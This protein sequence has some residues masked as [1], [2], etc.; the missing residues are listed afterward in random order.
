MSEFGTL[1]QSIESKRPLVVSTALGRRALRFSGSQYFEDLLV[2]PTD[3]NLHWFWAVKAEQVWSYH[4][5]MDSFGGGMCLWVTDS[6][7]YELNNCA[8]AGDTIYSAENVGDWQIV[9][10][11]V[12]G[13]GT[14]ILEIQSSST[15]TY[16]L[17]KMYADT[18]S[19]SLSYDIFHRNGGEAFRGDLGE[20]IVIGEALTSD[21]QAQ[22]MR[23]LSEK[24]LPGPDLIF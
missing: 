1:T 20:M 24:W 3:G 16:T 11:A 15:E 23:M 7:V 18:L 14:S 2:Q 8:A 19:T 12:L 5:L 9:H 21:E 4:N 10:V 17:S 13:D 22:I 6:N